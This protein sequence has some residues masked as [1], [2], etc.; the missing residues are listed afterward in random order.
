MKVKLSDVR[1]EIQ[2]TKMWAIAATTSKMGEG[3]QE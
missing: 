2:N 1:N 3:I